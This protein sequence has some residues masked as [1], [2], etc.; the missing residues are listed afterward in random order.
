MIKF[1]DIDIKGLVQGVGFRPYI[2]RLA[3][4][5]N[6]KGFV[7]NRT[8]GVKIILQASCV[9]K[10]EFIRRVKSEKPDVAEI[11]HID[12]KETNYPTSFENF[13][14]APSKPEATGIT[15]ISPDIATCKAC[16]KDLETQ[17]HRISYPFINC[18]HCGPRFSIIESIPYDRSSTTM[19]QFEMCEICKKEYEN[20]NDRRFH[21]QPVACN[22]CGPVYTSYQH[23]HWTDN[24][25]TIVNR[26]ADCLKAGGII[27][28]KGIGGF[29]WIADAG[30]EKTVKLLRELKQ[31]HAKPFAIM[32]KDSKWADEHLSLSIIEKKQ[33]ESWRRPIVV[34]QEKEKLFP[35]VNGVLKTLGVMLPY[36]P[37]H[38]DLF[39]RADIPAFILTSANRP[40]EPMLTHNDEARKYLL[41]KSD[42]YIEHN[43]PIHNRVDDSVIRVIN[44]QPQIFRRARGYTPEPILHNQYVNG[45]LAFGAEMTSVFALGKENEILLSQFIGNLSNNE[46]FEAYKETIT[47][48]SSLFHF[49]PKYLVADLHPDYY[50]SRYAEELAKKNKL[51]LYKVQHH[52]AHA[53]S[54]MVEHKLETKCLALCLDGTGLGDDGKNWGGE[55]MLC[56]HTGYKR[57]GHLPYVPMPGGDQASKECWRM[58]VSHLHTLFPNLSD[59]LP[60]TF[61]KRI[62]QERIT[63]LVRL[64]N[65][66]MQLPETSSMGRLFDAISALTGICDQNSFQAEAAIRLEHAAT[67]S[68]TEDCYI[69]SNDES[70][71]LKTLFEGILTDYKRKCSPADIARKFHNTLTAFL[72][73]RVTKAAA[74]E[75]T[76]DIVLSGGVFQNKLLSEL[77][78]KSLK[79]RNIYVYYPTRVPCNDGGIAVGQLAIVAAHI[80]N[81]NK[82]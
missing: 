32:C 43:R 14:I 70:W 46:G 42:L 57:L 73:D 9:D 51:P 48:L 62:G 30:N 2:Y 33:L 3:K 23:K 45:G 5:L 16:L 78:I 69:F 4:E 29:N 26:A 19:K 81:I 11:V 38:Y 71:D 64:L 25:E 40:G 35:L 59:H 55:L 50:S 53:V 17:Y 21:A 54:V 10:D 66:P 72:T 67:Q 56:S 12:V 28:L 39:R 41:D 7:D 76:R 80:R 31:R 13:L 82:N 27:A 61:I 22:H 75:K 37:I 79:K 58:T 65:S 36:L 34:L 47:R 18:T 74:N 77:L 6:L 68:N 60:E 8:G 24:Y 52:H 44:N 1:Y 49:K 63:S 20:P 15:R